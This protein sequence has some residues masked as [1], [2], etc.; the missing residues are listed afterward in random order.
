LTVCNLVSASVFFDGY[1]TLSCAQ[2]LT[3]FRA[4]QRRAL[5]LVPAITLTCLTAPLQSLLLS[6]Q[7]A[8]QQRRAVITA[9]QLAPLRGLQQ[10]CSLQI[11]DVGDFEHSLATTM[12]HLTALT[13]LVLAMRPRAHGATDPGGLMDAVTVLT[14]LEDL[15]LTSGHGSTTIERLPDSVSRLV[16]LRQ[17]ELREI[18]L[19]HSS[20]LTMLTGLETLVVE[21]GQ[22]LDGFPQPLEPVPAGITA[23]RSL[24]LL[25]VA[26]FYQRVPPLALPALTSLQLVAPSFGEVCPARAQGCAMLSRVA[27]YHSQH[28]RASACPPALYPTS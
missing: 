15:S 5:G 8:T 11:S 10:L 24:Q 7:D 4:P 19:M 14:R 23:L 2:A 9:A 18:R 13:R 25:E 1:N 17:L 26:C 27:T 28:C 22:P 20:Q 12:R 21:G 3:L 16:R 6:C